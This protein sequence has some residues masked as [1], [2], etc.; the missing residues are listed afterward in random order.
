MRRAELR[1]NAWRFA[2]R[3]AQ[4]AAL[5]GAPDFGFARQFQL[6]TDCVRVHKVGDYYVG[7]SLTDYRTTDES[8]YSI[9]GGVILTDYPAPLNIVYVRDETDVS[10]FDALMVDAV[11]QKLALAIAPILT[12][13]ASKQQTTKDDYRDTI[14]QAKRVNAIEVPPEPIPDDSWMLARV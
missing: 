1:A 8:A 6:P 2:L 5:A 14:A 10:K 7:A 4:L 11:A 12:Q 9:E 13:S 3:R